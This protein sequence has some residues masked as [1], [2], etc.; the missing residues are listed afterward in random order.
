MRGLATGVLAPTM[1]INLF[2]LLALGSLGVYGAI[3]R[4]ATLLRT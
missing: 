4:L 3:R 2:Y 1:P